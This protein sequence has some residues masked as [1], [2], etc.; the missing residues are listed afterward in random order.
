MSPFMKGVLGF[1]GCA[2]VCGAAYAIGKRVGREETLREVELEEKRIAAQKKPEPAPVVVIEK[3]ESEP[4]QEEP[5][6]IIPVQPTPAEN[7]RKKHSG[8]KGKLFGGIGT[9]KDLL[10][11]P[12][13]KKLTMTVEDGDLVARISQKE[14]G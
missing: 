8:I 7:V 13:G 4:V 9:I 1:I 12:E 5:T 3:Q 14:G 10:S 11:S 2:G 6:E